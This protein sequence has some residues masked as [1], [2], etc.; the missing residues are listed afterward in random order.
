[1]VL[2]SFVGELGAAPLAD[3]C[4][5]EAAAIAIASGRD[6][7]Q[8]CPWDGGLG[9]VVAVPVV[10]EPEGVEPF[11]GAEVAGTFEDISLGAEVMNV[12]EG[13]PKNAEAA[14]QG[15][16]FPGRDIP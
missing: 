16:V 11:P 2:D 9:V 12:L 6:C 3:I 14:E 7:G 8:F 5:E 4:G 1:M 10:I 15:E 13:G